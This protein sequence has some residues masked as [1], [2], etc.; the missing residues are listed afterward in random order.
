MEWFTSDWHFNH[1]KDFIYTARGFNSIYEHD[2]ALLDNIN[3]TVGINDHLY[4]LGDLC[5]GGAHLLEDNR[6]KLT[7]IKC[8]NIHIIRGNHCTDNRIAM[9]Q[10]LENVISISGAEFYKQG[11]WHYYLSHY[12]TI[13]N[14]YGN[15]KHPWRRV[16]N[17]HGHTHSDNKFEFM[18]R[19]IL[20]YNVAV[21]AHNNYPVSIEQ[22]HDD[23]L[24]Y[25][26]NK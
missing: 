25:C 15:D 17:L 11:K 23:I 26:R 12:P 21:D 8:N 3:A 14:N 19:G 5:L 2:S 6:K 24:D 10:E 1:N 22:I 9:Y 18:D 20:S 16:I 4:V 7:S 13:T